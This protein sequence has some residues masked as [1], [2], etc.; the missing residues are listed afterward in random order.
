MAQI[1]CFGDF[2]YFN[3]PFLGLV[4]SSKQPGPHKKINNKKLI[5][6]NSRYDGRHVKYFTVHVEEYATTEHFVKLPESCKRT[7]SFVRST[8]VK[9]ECRERKPP[10]KY[11][12]KIRL[13]EVNG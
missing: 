8:T 9:R 6:L 11:S 10:R 1:S 5:R 7:V 4:R 12:L 2:Y 3:L 13:L